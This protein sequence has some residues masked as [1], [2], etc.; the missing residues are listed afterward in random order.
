MAVEVVFCSNHCSSASVCGWYVLPETFTGNIG[1]ERT[2][3]GSP[4]SRLSWQVPGS[5][6]YC[7]AGTRLLTNGS[8]IASE[9]SWLSA[10]T[11]WKPLKT[12]GEIQLAKAKTQRDSVGAASVKN[13]WKPST[14][15]SPTPPALFSEKRNV[16]GKSATLSA[17][18]V[19]RPA[20]ISFTTTLKICSS[21]NWSSRKT[22]R[23]EERRVGKECRY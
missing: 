20:L 3:T 22:V 14:Q 10:V 11:S 13:V 9:I 4:V 7:Q 12:P 5:L 6:G 17:P 19:N 1:L 18:V 16:L 15:Q 2:S 23:S 21:K 8:L